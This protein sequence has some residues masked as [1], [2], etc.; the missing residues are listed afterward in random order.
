MTAMVPIKRR[1]VDLGDGQ[2]HLAERGT[3][4][5]LLLLG[6]TPRGWR[7]FKDLLPALPASRRV[8]AVDLPGLGASDPMP[9]PLTI[10]AVAD[11]LAAALDG[12][13]IERTDLFGMHTG[14]KVAAALAARRPDRVGRL[15]LAGQSHSLH[16]DPAARNAALGP[17]L[18]R[19]RAEA[20]DTGD[21]DDT[22]LRAWLGAKLALDQTWWAG[23]A[24][25]GRSDAIRSAEAKAI[26]F[27]HG[28]RSAVPIYHAVFAFDLAAA[29]EAIEAETMV[30]ELQSPEEADQHGTGEHLATLIRRGHHKVLPVDHL[31]AMERQPAAIA[32]TIL[33]FL[34]GAAA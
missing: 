26:D 1:Y 10:E 23:E 31:A 8:V 32:A 34:E 27:L 25:S 16:I 2:L 28:W 33:P 17:S 9:G 12:L 13:H 22:R 20:G 30:L 19:Y 5:P 6:E 15:V 7:F 18:A 21:M 24:P 14:N 3:G 4:A 29:A 11:R